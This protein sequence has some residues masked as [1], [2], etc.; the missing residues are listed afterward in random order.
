MVGNDGSVLNR[1]LNKRLRVVYNDTSTAVGIKEGVL[2]A[3]DDLEV[4]LLC[5]NTKTNQSEQVGIP[6]SKIVRWE[7][8]SQ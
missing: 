4:L 3:F 7:G 2:L 6:R 1:F 8:D 5:K